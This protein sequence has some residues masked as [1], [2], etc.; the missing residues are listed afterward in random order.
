MVQLLGVCGRSTLFGSDAYED[1]TATIQPHSFR[2]WRSLVGSRQLAKLTLVLVLEAD[3]VTLINS[4]EVLFLLGH[5]KKKSRFSQ[6]AE[7]TLECAERD[8]RTEEDW[9]TRWRFLEEASY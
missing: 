7:S 2:T 5:S 9:T 1:A 6:L 8:A 4:Q 3:L